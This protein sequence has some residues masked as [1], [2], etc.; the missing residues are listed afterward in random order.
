MLTAV[1]WWLSGCTKVFD[2]T[3]GRKHY[4]KGGAYNH[5]A[6]RYV[7]RCGT[8]CSKLYTCAS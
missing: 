3:P 1:G 6:G 8:V 2:V 7:C 4:G 5:F